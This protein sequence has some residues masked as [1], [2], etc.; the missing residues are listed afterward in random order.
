M[1]IL[2]LPRPVAVAVAML[3][4][5]AN[6]YAADVQIYGRID[7]GLM[8]ENSNPSNGATEHSTSMESGIAGASLWGFKIT[9]NLG[10][11][12]KVN[13]RLE[14]KINSDDGSLGTEGSIFDRDSY[15]ELE[16]AYGSVRFGRTG[17]LA[18]GVAGGIFAGRTNPFGVVYKTAGA[19]NVFQGAAH[20]VSNMVWYESPKVAGFTFYGQYS[21]G[22]GLSTDPSEGDDSVR[23]SQKDR[24]AA[25]GVTYANRGLRLSLVADNYFYNDVDGEKKGFDDPQSVG[26]AAD[27]KFG[28]FRVYGG[29][30]FAKNLRT[31][32]FGMNAQQG[33]ANIFMVG[34]TWDV[35]GGTFMTSSAFGK[36]DEFS[37]SSSTGKTRYDK[38]LD[39]W[40]F[41]LGYKYPLSK[42]TMIYGVVSYRDADLNYS[43]TTVASGKVENRDE[44]EKT[45]QVMFGIQH[46]F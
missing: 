27:Y 16:S 18:S 29:Y 28:S 21:N 17:M 44:R 3:A 4:L 2:H 1:K 15:I 13:V 10:N 12:M 32:I 11:G 43:S 30:Q 22:T 38:E 9:E 36:V 23:C 34:A 37:Y 14:G 39:A 33:D 46:K 45:N 31:S 26:F 5:G 7:T 35:W 42:R 19:L 41:A 20:R 25:L 8:Y 40:Q 6:A 24:Y